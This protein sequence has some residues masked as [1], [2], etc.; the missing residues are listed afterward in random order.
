MYSPPWLYSCVFVQYDHNPLPLLLLLL[1]PLPPPLTAAAAAAFSSPQSNEEGMS[2]LCRLG[3]VELVVKVENELFALEAEALIEEERWVGGGDVQG[4]ILPHTCLR[5]EKPQKTLS[6]RR[7]FTLR[8][9]TRLD[10]KF[11]D[12]P[13]KIIWKMFIYLKHIETQPYL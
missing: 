10:M 6:T 5:E 13:C 11:H 8:V 9:H 7:V 12:F 4:Y 1:P 2:A 3:R